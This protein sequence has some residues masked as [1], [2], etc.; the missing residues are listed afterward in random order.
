MARL[1][2]GFS[3]IPKLRV[4]VSIMRI[5]M[6]ILFVLMSINL[7]VASTEKT[8]IAVD[9]KA[10]RVEIDQKKGRIEFSGSVRATRGTL[11]MTCEKLVARYKKSGEV[12]RLEIAGSLTVQGR[13]FSARAGSGVYDHESGRLV[14]TGSPSIKRGPNRVTGERILVFVDDERVVVEKARGQVQ[15]RTQSKG[16]K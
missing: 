9:I 12:L 2:N 11:V 1:T 8:A 16:V 3:R 14:L 10:D 13:D 15:L 6:P 4:I 7:S 5:Y